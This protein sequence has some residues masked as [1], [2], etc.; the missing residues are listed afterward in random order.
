[1][2]ELLELIRNPKKKLSD[3]ADYLKRKGARI[4]TGSGGVLRFTREIS[5]N[6]FAQEEPMSCMAACVRQLIK[7]LG[8]HMS[9]AEV[10]ILLKTADDGTFDDNVIPALKKIFKEMDIVPV[11][12]GSR[13]DLAEDAMKIS[14]HGSWIASIHPI[15]GMRHSVIVDRIVGKEVFI[16]DPWPKEGIGLSP[17]GVEGTVDL[18]EFLKAWNF[19]FTAAFYL[20]K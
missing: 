2:K 6:V 4:L 13:G 19:G 12:A 7:D 14:R 3:V 15:G 5:R 10:R 11:K 8:I 1:L 17:F 9:E 20:K 18:D 16:R